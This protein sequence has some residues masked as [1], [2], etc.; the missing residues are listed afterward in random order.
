MVGVFFFKGD[1]PSCSW[2]GLVTFEREIEREKE[3]ESER[4]RELPNAKLGF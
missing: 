1:F 3:R 4:E 2:L